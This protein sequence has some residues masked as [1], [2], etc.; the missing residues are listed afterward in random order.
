[1]IK[2]IRKIEEAKTVKVVK[3]NMNDMWTRIILSASLISL[4]LP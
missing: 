3:I 4:N 1:M 2:G